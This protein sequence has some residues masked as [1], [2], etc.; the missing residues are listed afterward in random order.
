MV[1]RIILSRQG[2]VKTTMPDALY[3]IALVLPSPLY[4]EV[5]RLKEYF[6]D[7]YNSKAAL[8]SPPHI[9]LHMP[10]KWKEKREQELIL[11]LKKFCTGRK[12]LEI[13]LKNF[14]CFPP[15]VIF[16][17][18]VKTPELDRLQQD[19]AGF[20]RSELNLIHA[21]WRNHPFNPHV[22]LAFRDLK[23]AAFADAWP[24]FQSRGFEA[25]V[26]I[27]AITLLK[28]NGQQWQKREEFVLG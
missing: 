5:T 24:E 13:E 6:R 14:G 3:F 19:L 4:E 27:D 21:N 20:C 22:T 10:F 17:D 11:A 7:R 18:V 15:R 25:K 16:I 26:Q 2:R 12:G 23:K 1:N 8:R 9:T 28:H